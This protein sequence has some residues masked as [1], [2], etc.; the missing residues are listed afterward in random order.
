MKQ[1]VNS[2]SLIKGADY[3]SAD[4]ECWRQYIA[5]SRDDYFLGAMLRRIPKI[6]SGDVLLTPACKRTV[7]LLRSVCRKFKS[8]RAKMKE[9]IG[10]MLF[11]HLC[12]IVLKQYSEIY[13]T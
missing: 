4:S 2:K 10:F 12:K 8:I 9:S 1:I 13:I 5:G 11:F 6:N 3:L 7:R